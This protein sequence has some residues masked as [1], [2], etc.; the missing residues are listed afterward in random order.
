MQTSEATP[1]SS[2]TGV[3][4]DLRDLYLSP[5]DPALERDLSSALER[6]K[7][8]EQQYRGRLRQGIDPTSLLEALQEFESIAEQMDK[9]VIYAHLLHAADT[10]NPRY[11][12]LLQS[13]LER[14][15]QIKKHL[16]F[17]ELEWMDLP[18]EM[19][20]TLLTAP[21]I[22]R[23]R[24]YLEKARLFR[25]HKLSEP[26]E[27]ILELKANTST[28]SFQR[29]FDEI[30]SGLTIQLG[31][32]KNAQK[33][34]LDQALTKLHEPDRALRKNVAQ[35]ITRVLRSHARVL[36]YIFNTLVLDH[37]ITDELRKFLTPM[38]SR[39][40]SNEVEPSTVDALMTACENSYDIVQEYY[41]LKK[42]LLGVR[43]LYDYD[44][45]APIY[46]ELPQCDWASGRRIV[47]EAYRAFSPTVAQIVQEFFDK[48][49]IDAEVRFGKAGGAFSA[50]TVPSVHPYILMN[51][52]DKLRDVMT[53]AHE[54]GHGVH[55]YLSRRVGHLQADT[56][57]TMAEMASTFGELLTFRKLLEEIQDPRVKLA[58]LCSKIEDSFATIFRQIVL[59]R[60]EQRLH[61]ARR[62]QGELTPERI[63]E[64]WWTTNQQM[65]G[66]SV[67]LTDD[68][69]W[70][71]LYISHFIH[72]PFYCYAYAFGELLVFALYQQYLREGE[73]FVPKYLDLLSAG[74]SDSPQK[75]LAPLGI[76]T[77][78]PSFWN[79]GLKFL[80]SMVRE[81]QGLASSS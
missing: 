72:V 1:R 68:Y 41:H 28:R 73:A 63:G 48:N 75:L 42:R 66:D 2:A 25:P 36:T 22:A 13:T 23:Y 12:A 19:A 27:K 54:L 10:Q 49:W 4:W 59:T 30:V 29:L 43:T 7:A 9:P 35:A 21:A 40:L 77:S 78:D 74:G 60:F 76:D 47:L 62:T 61:E 45:Y 11:G 15:S 56:P 34:T 5:E 33:L 53:L 17:F 20:Q 71:W 26:E 67:K 52:T 80:R 14:H 16:L 58:L 37:K 69:R 8:F 44:R 55:Q 38:S 57:L 81:A 70:W 3:T 18:D 64:L 32:S 46:G 6:A 50:S 65:F 79:T 51:Y 39:H 31:R 24:H